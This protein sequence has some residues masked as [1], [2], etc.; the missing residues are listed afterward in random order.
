ML[1][2]LQQR[3]G[4]SLKALP[5]TGFRHILIALTALF[6]V[7]VIAQ[8]GSIFVVDGWVFDGWIPA[9]ERWSSGVIPYPLLLVLQLLILVS[10]VSG[11]AYPGRWRPGSSAI[12]TMKWLALAYFLIMLLRL[13]VALSG[14]SSPP[15]WQMPLPALFHLVLAGYLYLFAQYHNNL[16]KTGGGCRWIGH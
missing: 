12:R 10:M 3:F 11:C 5:T 16:R 9:F 2:P 6:G 1:C 7:R 8:L 4:C 15:W 14:V 13:I